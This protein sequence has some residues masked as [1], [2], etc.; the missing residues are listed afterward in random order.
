MTVDASR[1]CLGLATSVGS[2]IRQIVDT[3]VLLSATVSPALS[4]SR[5]SYGS[6]APPLTGIMLAFR[7]ACRHRDL[8]GDGPDKA[9]QFAS[10]RSGDNVG[11]LASAGELA[12]AG[13]QPQLRFPGDLADR[14]GLALLPE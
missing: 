6:A 4:G 11:W 14:L 2:M 10:D 3:R 8:P 1:S 12:I 9:C 7:S 13:A 5:K